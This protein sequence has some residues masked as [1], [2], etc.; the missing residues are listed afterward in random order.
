MFCSSLPRRAPIICL[1][2]FY[3]AIIP[4]SLLYSQSQEAEQCDGTAQYHG[5][6]PQLAQSYPSLARSD[7]SARRAGVSTG[8]PVLYSYILCSAQRG[9]WLPATTPHPPCHL[10]PPSPECVVECRTTLPCPRPGWLPTHPPRSRADSARPGPGLN[11][12]TPA[13]CKPAPRRGWTRGFAPALAA[14][15]RATGSTKP[16]ERGASSG[17]CESTNDVPT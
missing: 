14:S 15:P 11:P 3:P 5:S 8:T 4:I 2:R 10:I 16:P 6:A 17:A 1:R 9:G 7:S 12:P 13:A